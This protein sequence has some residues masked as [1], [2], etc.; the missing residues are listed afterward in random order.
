MQT[1][2]CYITRQYSSSSVIEHQLLVE[3]QSGDTLDKFKAE[4]KKCSVEGSVIWNSPAWT[5]NI[6]VFQTILRN[7]VN[8]RH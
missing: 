2:N 3:N 7:S 1:G 8:T 6:E 5:I 4:I